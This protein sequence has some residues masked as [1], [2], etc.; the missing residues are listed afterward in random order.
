MSDWRYRQRYRQVRTL[1]WAG[2]FFVKRESTK[3]SHD[4]ES[5]WLALIFH[6]P[7]G[8]NHVNLGCWATS[9]QKETLEWNFFS[10]DKSGREPPSP[11]RG[12]QRGHGNGKQKEVAQRRGKPMHLEESNHLGINGHWRWRGP[13]PASP[14]PSMKRCIRYINLTFDAILLPIDMRVIRLGS[15]MKYS[16]S[17]SPSEV[18]PSRIFLHLPIRYSW[19]RFPR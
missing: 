10:T 3:S 1:L 15:G 7:S 8:G 5:I 16:W 9:G 12:S 4:Y 13:R 14:Q 18:H 17:L 11:G 2:S 19:K 6:P